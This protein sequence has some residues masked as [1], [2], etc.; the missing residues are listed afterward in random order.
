MFFYWRTIDLLVWT[1]SRAHVSAWPVSQ[2]GKISSTE[3]TEMKG[4]P[5]NEKHHVLFFPLEYD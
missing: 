2:N 5:T 1:I 3:L 4:L